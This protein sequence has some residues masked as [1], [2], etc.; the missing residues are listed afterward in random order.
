VF[1]PTPDIVDA[2][3]A[4]RNSFFKLC[5][6]LWKID[7]AIR[8]IAFLAGSLARLSALFSFTIKARPPNGAMPRMAL[9]LL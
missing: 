1:S 6:P 8:S 2:R 4:R 9:E 5:E 3:F 7:L